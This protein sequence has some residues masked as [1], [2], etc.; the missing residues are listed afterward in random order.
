MQA[1]VHVRDAILHKISLAYGLKGIRVLRILHGH[2]NEAFQ[3]AT[4]KG[5]FALRRP[6]PTLEISAD[7]PNRLRQQLAFLRYLAAGDFPVASPVLTK[8]GQTIV[9]IK[10]VPYTLHP[11]MAGYPIEYSTVPRIRSISAALARFH[12]LA[13]GYSGHMDSFEPSFQTLFQHRL[14]E[15]YNDTQELTRLCGGLHTTRSLQF[16]QNILPDI[17]SAFEK[18]PFATLPKLLI[19]GRFLGR[20][21]LFQRNNIVAVLDFDRCRYEARAVDAVISLSHLAR[22]TYRKIPF[23]L[24]MVRAFLTSYNQ[25]L[26]FE[27]EELDALPA[28]IQ[29]HL[30]A[31]ALRQ[32]LLSQEVNIEEQ[33]SRARKF[34]KFV[35]RLSWLRDN[36]SSVNKVFRK[37]SLR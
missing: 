25:T 35:N 8:D 18:I 23:D 19:H 27:M 14:G 20:N 6:K 36:S 11:F 16:L 17:E 4:D 22:R 3:I 1:P 9:N 33:R 5:Y 37:V 10:G 34:Q 24:D 21:L 26:Q 13:A 7:Y 28:M 31:E 15:F 2:N 30:A 12:K 29:T 32:L